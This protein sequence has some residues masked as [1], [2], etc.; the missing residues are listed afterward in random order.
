[1]E[2]KEKKVV[3][4]AASFDTAEEYRL[5]N[6]WSWVEDQSSSKSDRNSINPADLPDFLDLFD[7]S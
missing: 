4:W 6:K 5:F 1:M 7:V 3:E 2:K